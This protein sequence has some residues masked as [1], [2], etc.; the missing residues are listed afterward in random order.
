MGRAPLTVRPRQVRLLELYDV[1]DLFV[2]YEI[3]YTHMG[4]DKPLYFNGSM[5]GA[6]MLSCLRGCVD[7]RLQRVGT[8]TTL[9]PHT[10]FLPP[11]RSRPQTLRGRAH[12]GPPHGRS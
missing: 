5:S 7:A 1:V 9:A 10:S 4:A 11:N 12:M 6:C 8:V 3:P 2:L